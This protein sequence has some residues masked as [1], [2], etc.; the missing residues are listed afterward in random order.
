M[1]D[2]YEEMFGPDW[3]ESQDK[4]SLW[5]DCKHIPDETLWALHLQFKRDLI[6]FCRKRLKAQLQRSSGRGSKSVNVDGI[7]DPNALTIGFARRF[8]P[9]KR[10]TLVFSDPKR[11][12]DILND[13]KKPVQIVFAG[14][15]HPADVPGKAIIEQLVKFARQPRFRKRIV[16]LEDYEMEVARH[17]VAGV[18]VWLNNPER[19]REASGTSGMKPALHGGLNLSILDGWWPEGFNRKNGWAIGKGKDHDGTQ[20]AD[21]RDVQNLYRLLEKE[22]VPLYFDRNAAGLPHKW[23][24]RMK[25]AMMTIPPVFNTHRQVKEYLTKYYLPAMRKAGNPMKGISTSLY[26][27]TTP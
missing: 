22:V 9:Y 16:F 8:A 1:G 5:A 17:M 26:H 25:N 2:L 6:G 24:V 23:I 20:A 10:A 13:R 7:L 3:Q 27:P 4:P 18:D 19:P 14:K 11:L 21:E 12:A 15:A